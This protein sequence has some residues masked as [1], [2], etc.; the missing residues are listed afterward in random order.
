[1]EECIAFNVQHIQRT[2]QRGWWNLY[3]AFRVW[4]TAAN[5]LLAHY[6][7]AGNVIW[8]RFEIRPDH[9]LRRFLHLNNRQPSNLRNRCILWIISWLY[10]SRE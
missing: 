3:S 8:S 10:T 2:G 1:V 4:S 5:S 7:V 6:N 9:R